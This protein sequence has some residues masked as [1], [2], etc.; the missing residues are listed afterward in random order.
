MHLYHICGLPPF[1]HRVGIQQVSADS[2]LE[3]TS[4]ESQV[5]RVEQSV[6]APSVVIRWRCRLMGQAGTV[7]PAKGNG[8]VSCCLLFQGQ[9]SCTQVRNYFTITMSLARPCLLPCTPS[10]PTPTPPALA[11]PTPPLASFSPAL[12]PDRSWPGASLSGAAMPKQDLQINGLSEKAS[13]GV[14]GPRGSPLP[15]WLAARHPQHVLLVLL[16]LSQA[17]CRQ[18][19]PSHSSASGQ[20]PA[21]AGNLNYAER[22]QIVA[23]LPSPRH[24]QPR[25]GA[26]TCRAAT[27]KL[28]PPGPME[29]ISLQVI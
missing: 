24:G 5:C 1:Q 26:S 23:S 3:S 15:G 10:P 19:I 16:P 22:F 11:L 25:Q 17:G 28:A 14:P 6:L 18:R 13:S 9:K 20:P 29:K 27:G 2:F 8:M 12:S 4:S 7:A 21:A